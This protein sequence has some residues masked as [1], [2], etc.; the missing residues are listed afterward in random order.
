MKTRFLLPIMLIILILVN[1]SGIVSVNASSLDEKPL[2]TVSELL[3]HHHYWDQRTITFS[4]EVIGQPIF[5]QNQVCIHLLDHQ[6]N[7]I[8]VWI[9]SD[10]LSQIKH[11]GKYRVKGDQIEVRGTFQVVCSNHPG[12]TDIH[13]EQFYILQEG[14]ITP[15]EK[16]NMIRILF[17]I[18]FSLILLTVLLCRKKQQWKRTHY[19]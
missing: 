15:V 3:N 19:Q 10:F 17:G 5:S 1:L 7:A 6:G 9:N 8:G 16:P 11:F 2:L 14:F 12:D 13:A 4:G 18:V